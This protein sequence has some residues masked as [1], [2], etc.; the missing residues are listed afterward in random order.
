MADLEG[1]SYMRTTRGA[2]PV[3]YDAGETFPVGGSKVLRQTGDDQVTLIG[4][5]VTL[6]ECL[7]AAG[8]LAAD[9]ITARVIDLYSVKPTDTATLTAAAAATGGRLI[10]AEDHHPE[11]GLGSAVLDALTGAGRTDLA[12]A[13][14]A[15]REMPSSGTPAELLGA[16]GISASN[17]AE[18]ARRLLADE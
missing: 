18:A 12:V 2:Y 5:G 3:L 9:G 11:G 10:I 15:V 1:V 8:Q 7:A 4:A 13:H 16:S 6:H 17:I 14:L